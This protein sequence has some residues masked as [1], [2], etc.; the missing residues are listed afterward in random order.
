MIGVKRGLFIFFLMFITL[1]TFSTVDAFGQSGKELPDWVKNPPADTAE[2][3]YFSGQGFSADKNISDAEKRATDDLIGGIMRFVGVRIT[4]KTSTNAVATADSFES[5]LRKEVSQTGTARVTSFQIVNKWIHTLDVGITVYILARYNKTE[6]YKEKERLEKLFIET[7]EAVEKPQREGDE[8]YRQGRYYEAVIRFLEA[9]LAAAESDLENKDIYVNRNIDDAMKTL[10]R[11]N[12]YK[13]SDNIKAFVGEE[14][15]QPFTLKVAAGPV[16]DTRGVAEVALEFTYKKLKNSLKITETTIIKTDKEGMIQFIHPICQFVGG[17]TVNVTLSLGSY[18][19]KLE[20][21]PTKYE[22]KVNGFKLLAL[23][24]TVTFNFTVFAKSKDIPS[25]IVMADLDNN[26]TCIAGSSKTASGVLESL[27]QNGFKIKII[28]L[29]P[30]LILAKS[31]SDILK[32]IKSNTKDIERSIY[33]SAQIIDVKKNG[34]KYIAKVTGTVKVID[35]KNGSIL[36]EKT[37][38]DN[39]LGATQE[40]AKDSAF[41]QMGIKL[42]IALAQGVP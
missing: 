7:I 38:K 19:A 34:P 29:N 26:G 24:K 37:I 22:T 27:T 11:I 5:I 42:G 3:V 18:L 40:E 33:G 20:N 9:T 31:D 36:F 23:S 41:K 4:S 21:I 25:G 6:L 39:A 2:F 1:F 13:L 17:E 8:Y 28:S 16:E 10:E 15:K 35:L 30:A 14:V 12:L 32:L